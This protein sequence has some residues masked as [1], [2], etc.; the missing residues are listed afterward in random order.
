MLYQN[1]QM[2][3][4]CMI[5]MKIILMISTNKL[6]VGIQ[7]E[8]NHLKALPMSV[9]Y[10]SNHTTVS[11]V[12]FILLKVTVKCLLRPTPYRKSLAELTHTAP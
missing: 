4:V 11:I 3:F 10:L 2:H 5:K 1:I 7:R 12:M 9:Y 6:I 8:E